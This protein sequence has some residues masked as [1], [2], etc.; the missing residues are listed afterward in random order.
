MKQVYEITLNVRIVHDIDGC[1]DFPGSDEVGEYISQ[2]ICDELTDNKT[3]VGYEV[4]NSSSS[5]EK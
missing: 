2:L 5:V 1:T 3:V 4:V